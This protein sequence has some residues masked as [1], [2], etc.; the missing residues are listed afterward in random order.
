MHTFL[1]AIVSEGHGNTAV[2]TH[3]RLLYDTRCPVST[4]YSESCCVTP[5]LPHRA[6]RISLTSSSSDFTLPAAVVCINN[7]VRSAGATTNPGSPPTPC[8]SPASEVPPTLFPGL[9]LISLQ[10]S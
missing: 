7:F 8:P 3:A 2:V 4:R 5:G 9:D 6:H 10:N 1:H